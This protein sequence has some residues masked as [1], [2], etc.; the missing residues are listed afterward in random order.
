LTTDFAEVL[1]EVTR[2]F[3]VIEQ[4]LSQTSSERTPTETSTKRTAGAR[5]P[6]A[7]S[8]KP[9]AALD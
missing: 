6:E 2:A 3:A 8:R 7:G 5:S 4:K 1:N 9:K